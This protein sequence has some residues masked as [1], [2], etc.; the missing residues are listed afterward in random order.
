MAEKVGEVFSGFDGEVCGFPSP[1]GDRRIVWLGLLVGRWCEWRRGREILGEALSLA[2][3]SLSGCWGQEKVHIKR[4]VS[5]C[6][7]Q[8][9]S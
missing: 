5:L 7:S 8:L 1:N 2:G 3:A 4:N 9:K 6:R